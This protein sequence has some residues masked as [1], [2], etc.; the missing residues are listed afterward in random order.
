M[1][2]DYPIFS[3][4]ERNLSHRKSLPIV[5]ALVLLFIPLKKRLVLVL[6]L[7]T[8]CRLHSIQIFLV[9]VVRLILIFAPLALLQLI[10]GL[11]SFSTSRS[12]LFHPWVK[13]CL[14]M[15]M[16]SCLMQVFV[17]VLFQVLGWDAVM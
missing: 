11:T 16:L 5:L 1:T 9:V 10:A 13:Y 3:K 4:F 8:C 15:P 17:Y 7:V 2:V 6:I 14:K 12:I